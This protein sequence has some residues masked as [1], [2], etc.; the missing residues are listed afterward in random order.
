MAR[1]VMKT[2][3]FFFTAL[4]SVQAYWLMGAANFSDVENFITTERLDPIINPGKVSGHVHSVLGGSNF[5]MNTNTAALRQSECTSIPIPE[6]KS[7]YWFP[8]PQRQL[9]EL[10]WRSSHF[11]MISG[12]PTLRTYDPN[13]HAQQAITFL[14]LD[15]NG[16]TTR[17][18]ELPSKSC[19]SGVRAQ[20]NFP[21]CWDGKNTDSPDHKSHVTFLSGGPDSGTCS[22]P[23]FPVVL[24]RIFIEVYWNTGEFESLRSAAMNP[25]QPFVYA[26]GDPTGYGYHADFLNGWDKGVLQ[27][28]VDQCHCNIY[29]DPTCCADQGI[30]KLNKGKNCRITKAI[31]EQTT[32][33]LSKLP[34]NNPVQQGGTRATMFVDTSVPVLLSPVYA[35]TGDSPTQVGKPVVA[36]ASG[37]PT[38]SSAV[39]SAVASSSVAVS[40]S[41]AVPSTK[42][43]PSSTVASQ[44]LTSIAVSPSPTEHSVS[45]HSMAASSKP[46]ATSSMLSAPVSSASASSVPAPPV[47]G[48]HAS[49]SQTSASTSRSASHTSMT[50][51]QPSPTS[52]GESGEDDCEE[53][54]D[55][56]NETD[57]NGAS[58]TPVPTTPVPSSSG[59][60]GHSSPLQTPTA[61][62]SKPPQASPTSSGNDDDDEDCEE[63]NDQG[64]TDNGASS[65][66]VTAPSATPASPSSGSGSNH[67]NPNSVHSQATSAKTVDPTPVT[68]LALGGDAP[69]PTGGN[70]LPATSIPEPVCA[71]GKFRHKR[72]REEKAQREKR[73]LHHA[74]SIHDRFMGSHHARAF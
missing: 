56:D 13:S 2:F 20:V 41:A 49:L 17:H 30:F 40:S 43:V 37:G 6:D 15:F 50:S 27:K 4:T 54:D 44:S 55:G 52:S 39:S 33:T 3:V 1:H 62:A 31:D 68:T 5:R 67:P 70:F 46:A 72:L 35:Y 7:S 10:E 22:D 34:G 29:G 48:G 61:P 60:Q 38:S 18:N 63:G 74:R 57:N 9:Y 26:Y 32:G 53:G 28:A 69:A 59:N 42:S 51:V 73:A 11:R 8:A 14:C 64:E 25:S 19:P 12:D 24:P 21:S 58:S 71:A 47:S 45:S 23:K 65:I 66:A 36:P 16:V